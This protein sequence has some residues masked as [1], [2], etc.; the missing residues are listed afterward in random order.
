M[1][2]SVAIRVGTVRIQSEIEM[3]KE[4][5]NI[6]AGG[7]SRKKHTRG[8]RSHVRARRETGAPSIETK[9]FIQSKQSKRG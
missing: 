3:D 9:L 7:L 8:D 1:I 2:S 5:V 4:K 6:T